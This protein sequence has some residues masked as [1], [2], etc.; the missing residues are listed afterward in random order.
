LQDELFQEEL[1]TQPFNVIENDGSFISMEDAIRD[2]PKDPESSLFTDSDKD[3]DVIPI[4]RAVMRDV[5][6]KLAFMLGTTANLVNVVDPICGG[7]AVSATPNIAR[8]LTPIICQSPGIVAW[9]QKTSNVM[10]YINLAMAC[11]PVAIAIYTHHF[12]RHEEKPN[13]FVD[14]GNFN[15]NP[16]MYGVS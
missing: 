1:R 10:L 6:G 8:T 11:W 3:S 9:F 15:I 2:T 12:A 13:D 4:T 7:A 16:D 14:N 5:E